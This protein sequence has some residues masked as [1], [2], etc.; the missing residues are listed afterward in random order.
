MKL[1]RTGAARV[2]DSHLRIRAPKKMSG[3]CWGRTHSLD[4]GICYRL[5]RRDQRGALH[6][7]IRSYSFDELAND[8]R[9]RTRIAHEIHQA[10]RA[11]REQVDTVDLALMG[12]V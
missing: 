7:F 2:K 9:I 1:K 12:V 8:P 4:N 5:F 3:F 10:R 11:L 6:Y